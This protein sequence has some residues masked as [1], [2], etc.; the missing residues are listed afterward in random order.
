MVA[1]RLVF[2]PEAICVPPVNAPVVELMVYCAI[3]P[4]AASAT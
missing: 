4:G 1:R 2:A 3:V